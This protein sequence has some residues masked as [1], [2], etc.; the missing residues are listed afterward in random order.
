MSEELAKT[1]VMCWGEKGGVGKSTIL[2]LL[3]DYLIRAGRTVYIIEA[4]GAQTT[5]TRTVVKRSSI[6]ERFMHV[7]ANDERRLRNMLSSVE[8][9]P[10][11]TVV[12]VDFGAA[13]QR[14]SLA[15]LPGWLYAAEQM[16]AQL[17]IAY[18][19]TAE[20]EAAQAVKSLVEG[21]RAVE[22]PMDVVYALNDH[23]AKT[24]DG[25]PILQSSKFATRFPEFSSA[26]KVWVGPLPPVVTEC[27][28]EAGLLPSAGVDSEKISLA[29]RG[30]LAGLYPRI[31]AIARQIIGEAEPAPLPS[32]GTDEDIEL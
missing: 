32:D 5:K 11:G 13:T 18:V 28:S 15:C 20:V 8:D 10:D 24:A 22:K 19:L 6:A 7:D 25:Y 14:A 2:L 26:P 12:L 17:R 31:D 16:G 1:I 27:I 30:L 4:E 29:S 9:K 21:I 23:Q 3:L